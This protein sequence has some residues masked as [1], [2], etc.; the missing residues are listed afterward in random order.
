MC[1]CF[2]FL[3]EQ[4]LGIGTRFATSFL[5]DLEQIVTRLSL[6]PYLHKRQMAPFRSA[7]GLVWLTYSKTPGL[8]WYC[9]SGNQEILIR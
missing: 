7:K 3:S 2:I 6:L 1:N 8:K 4:V 5:C 9:E